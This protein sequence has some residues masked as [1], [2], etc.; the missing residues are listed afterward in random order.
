MSE[1]FI[2]EQYSE[3][4]QKVLIIES[5]LEQGT[6]VHIDRQHFLNYEEF[7]DYYILALVGKHDYIDKLVHK[8]QQQNL[9]DKV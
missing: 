2:A 6:I 3:Y 5:G 7:K 8:M 1:A 4:L 9:I